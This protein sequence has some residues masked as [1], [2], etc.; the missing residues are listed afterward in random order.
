MDFIQDRCERCQDCKR[1]EGGVSTRDTA[2][3]LE[4]WASL[5]MESTRAGINGI[6][7]AQLNRCLLEPRLNPYISNSRKE[8]IVQR[9]NRFTKAIWEEF[10]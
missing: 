9:G 5:V 3:T 10:F 2:R 1:Q 8:G 6:L 7:D 4:L